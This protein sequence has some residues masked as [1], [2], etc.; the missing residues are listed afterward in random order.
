[1]RAST[2]R[3]AA[4]LQMALQT[5]ATQ[6][7]ASAVRAST[8]VVSWEM[9]C[10]A[11]ILRRVNLTLRVDLFGRDLFPMMRGPKALG[12]KLLERGQTYPIYLVSN[13]GL[14][15]NFLLLFFFLFFLATVLRCFSSRSM[16][17]SP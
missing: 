5:S 13:T 14:E 9:K 3:K 4:K 10:V 2:R 12:R 6:V 17:L 8:I 7:T 16:C 15:Y 1:M 11:V